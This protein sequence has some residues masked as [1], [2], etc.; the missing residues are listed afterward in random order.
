LLLLISYSFLNFA[1]SNFNTSRVANKLCDGPVPID[2]IN[3]E[4]VD[5]I[6]HSLLEMTE[7]HD[8]VRN[9]P[10][11][12][13][14]IRT[15]NP[16]QD[17]IS[18]RQAVA[19]QR[20]LL[21]MLSTSAE[22]E[23]KELASSKE[24]L[25]TTNGKTAKKRKK[26][27]RDIDQ[28]LDVLSVAV[29]KNLPNLLSAFKADVMA[30][31]D[32]TKLPATITSSVLSLPSR[33]TDFQNLVKALCQLFLHSTDEQVL[34]NIAAALSQWAEG[35]HSRVS[36]VKMQLK[37]LSSALQN[38]LMELFADSESTRKKDRLQ[39]PRRKTRTTRYADSGSTDSSCEK[40]STLS[41]FDAECSIAQLMARWKILLMECQAKYLFEKMEGHDLEDMDEIEGLYNTISEAM[42]KRL[43]DRR[44]LD[45]RLTDDDGT[46][47]VVTVRTIWVDEDPNIHQVVSKGVGMALKVL[48]LLVAN[49]LADTL[50][51]LSD[52]PGKPSDQTMITADDVVDVDDLVVVRMRDRLV[53]LLGLC[54]DQHIV[55]SDDIDFTDEQHEFAASVQN[56]AGRVASDLRTLFPQGWSAA[57]DPVRKILA[58]TGGPEVSNLIGGFARWVQ[59]QED[60]TENRNEVASKKLVNDALLPLARVT[61]ANSNDFY[62]REAALVL[63]NITGS[64]TYATQTVV[65]WARILKKTNPVRMLES[66][67]A[68]LRLA[69][70]NWV[71]TDPEDLQGS[72]PT[73]EEVEAFEDSER[74]HNQM[75]VDMEHTSSKLS[76]TLGVGRLSD[77]SLK[78]SLL[79]FMKE[80]VRYAFD[81]NDKEE[82][83][84]VVGSRLPFLNL[85]AKYSIW[86]KKEKA[87]LEQLTD[88]ILQKESE[89]HQHPEFDE[90]HEDD[91]RALDE[92][93]KSLGMSKRVSYTREATNTVADDY[94]SAMAT[95][96]PSADTSVT[97]TS[98]HRFSTIGSQRSRLS[99]QSNLSPLY[100]EEI[101]RDED[102]LENSDTSP[103]PQKRRRLENSSRRADTSVGSTLSRGTFRTR[104]VDE[105]E[106][107]QDMSD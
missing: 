101:P 61:T 13:S 97:S 60:A 14:A 100:E 104:T 29:L 73:E 39:S 28:S 72:S 88:Y 22:I 105:E 54:F 85:L 32:L 51:K 40:L 27:D 96:S 91:L 70:E 65:S 26:T 86:V 106:H 69:F 16:Q 38:R 90:V 53:K 41:S 43:L 80:G 30:M 98:R 57:A 47:T 4:L 89:L 48:L 1:F 87:Q 62:R 31:R 58:L 83:D 93:K 92:L 5:D 68:C 8:L 75:F 25:Q 20:I 50:D 37:R 84:L 76:M 12:L 95:P 34:Q 56:A 19:T 59:F 11:I 35:D 67:M 77:A 45:D 52:K 9:W 24:T 15:E 18:D 42:G 71:N 79:G 49:E 103:T 36:E 82:D 63:A 66:H 6:I 17:G 2:K 3:I 74:I 55:E 78:K 81:G 94:G 46:K 33:R 21:R 64:G 44:P 10:V 107:A 7:H 99:V 23:R 102:D